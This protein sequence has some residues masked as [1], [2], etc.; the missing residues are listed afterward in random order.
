[1]S[2]LDYF[3]VETGVGVEVFKFFG[4]VGGGLKPEAGAESASAKCD[5]IHH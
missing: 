1:M 5:S 2:C 3:G 4:V